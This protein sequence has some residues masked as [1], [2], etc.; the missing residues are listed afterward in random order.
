MNINFSKY[1]SAGNDFVIVSNVAISKEQIIK[2]CN[3][4]F[5]IG[6]DGLIIVNKD[7]DKGFK[8]TF[9]NPDG[10]G[11]TLCGNGSLCSVDYALKNLNIIGNGFN[12][13]DGNHKFQIL[14]DNFYKISVR[15]CLLPTKLQLPNYDNPNKINFRD[16]F[17]FFINT[18][19]PHFVI[20]CNEL[21]SNE[22]MPT[23][24]EFRRIINAN[25]GGCNVDFVRV[26]NDSCLQIRT[27]ERGVEAETLSCGTGSIAAA[28]TFAFSNNLS[29]CSI[30]MN[31]KGG[32]HFVNLTKKDDAFKDIWL[33]GK[34]EL[35][36][37]GIIDI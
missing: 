16:N 30:Q 29:K 19:S 34:P 21:T 25:N 33:I 35:T 32:M 1:Q 22:L 5:G 10:S 24:K 37:K 2:I 20:F 23:A 4:K 15:D 36:F 14:N 12:A 27:F 3:R 31:N 17:G 18:G 28:I 26:I 6:S 7:S 11:D 9:Y 8:L 13:S